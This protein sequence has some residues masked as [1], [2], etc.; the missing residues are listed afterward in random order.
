MKLASLLS[1]RFGAMRGRS[2]AYCERERL[3]LAALAETP[4]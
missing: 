1:V 2:L 3:P 4:N